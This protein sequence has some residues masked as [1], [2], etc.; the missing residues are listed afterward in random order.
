MLLGIGPMR[1]LLIGGLVLTAS[2]VIGSLYVSNLALILAIGSFLG[3]GGPGVY[4]LIR[5]HNA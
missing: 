4:F 2:I 5:R 3:I 1:P